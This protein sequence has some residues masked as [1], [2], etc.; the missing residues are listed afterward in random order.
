MR[1]T[2][3]W[4]SLRL[5]TDL[6]ETLTALARQQALLA[7]GRRILAPADDP[8][9]T[10][11]ALTVRSRQS[12]NE[13][14]L[15]NIGE[16]RSILNAADST[17]RGVVA[18]LTRT[19]E[20]A[21]QGGN[22]TNG[23]VER[24]ATAA[25]VDQLL[26]ALVALGNTRGPRRAMLFGGQETTL[27]PYSAARDAD[28]AIVAV[29]VHDRGIDRATPVEVADGLTVATS[30]AGTTVFGGPAEAT[31]AFD[32][33][34]ALRDAL[35]ANDGDAVRSL[36]DDLAAALDRATL[37]STIVGTRI[38]WLDLVQDR[39]RDESLGLADSLARIENL[40]I[41]RA[42]H[43]LTQLETAYQAGLAAGARIIQ[44]SLLNFLR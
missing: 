33:L 23:P 41:P 10:A 32:V 39:V 16:V 27:A 5:A 21:V 29:T 24:Q 20:L 15:K 11:Q 4:V 34:I 17:L 44:Q 30:V 38:G 19:T 25:E 9:G 26:E 37:A 6:Q 3:A 12:A 18:T 43:D 7:T 36:L 42:V 8:G 40:D 35:R 28:G 13:Q 14:F 1:I 22:D 31:Y 2:P